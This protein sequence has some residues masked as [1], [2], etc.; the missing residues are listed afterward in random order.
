M[1]SGEM[2]ERAREC[3][4]FYGLGIEVTSESPALVDEVRRDFLYFHRDGLVGPERFA[5][6]LH[7]APPSFAKLPELP[8]AFLTPRNVCFRDTTRTYIDYYGEALGIFER[9]ARTFE[10][11][12]TSV[13]MLHEIAY[14]FMLS[15]VGEYLDGRG[16][17]RLHA[18]AVSHRGRGVL[19]ALPSGGGKSTMA[20]ALMQQPGFLL[21]AED[22]P[23]IDRRGQI[24]PFPLRIG[25]RP[26]SKVDVPERYLRTVS[27]MEFD[28]KTLI[29]M[30]YFQDRI[31]GPTDTGVILVGQRNL[32]EVSSIT[33][34]SRRA[35]LNAL[36][37]YMIVGLGIY[38]GME[39]LL[40]RGV[41]EV[42]GRFGVAASRLYNAVRL[43]GHAP[44]YRFVLGQN[45]FMRLG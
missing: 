38:Q 43:L 5:L 15:T 7:I 24:L 10:V 37:K 34:M 33:P 31:G 41:W 12:G 23:L 35:A 2:D 32:G 6:H 4:D 26:G 29:D 1:T 14:L 17:H 13:D 25:V 20:L 18:L 40:E 39:F 11:W 27:R 30:E 21:L 22:T 16:I 3:F 42:T 45:H 8:A 9:A 28:P 36:V 44:A 19:L